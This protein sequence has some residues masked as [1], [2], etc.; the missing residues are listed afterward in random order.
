M[1]HEKTAIAD[2]WGNASS[3]KRDKRL[4]RRRFLGRSLALCGAL[5]VGAT[6]FETVHLDVTQHRLPIRGLREPCRIVQLSDLHRS[7]C[8]SEGFIAHVVA[9]TNALKPDVI[10]LTGDFVTLHSYY[11]QSCVRQIRRLNARLGL[12]GVLGN[13]D[14]KCDQWQ[15]SPVIIEELTAA[16]VNLLTNRSER[17][18]N[19]LHLVGVDDYDTGNPD[20]NA[21]FRNVGLGETVI[22][23]THNP[24][25]FN[26]MCAY[27]CVTL[28]GHTHGGQVNL[29]VIT[30]LMT[31]ERSRYLRGWFQ[32]RG[33][34]GRMY[35]SRG[36]G[37]TTI[38]F[39]IR[40]APEIAV[41]ELSID[42]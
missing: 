41:F 14:Y 39:R 22:A 9:R 12:Y 11:I 28:A 10:L 26:E 36:L 40:S 27:E 23:M 20:L 2:N 29:P 33:R 31:D 19:G 7:W 35:V 18:D 24:L 25:M 1:E 3:V 15:G 13:H 16:G 38:P 6:A 8:V 42:D 37:L 17:L 21:A 32:E 30:R 34:P 5:G 4:T